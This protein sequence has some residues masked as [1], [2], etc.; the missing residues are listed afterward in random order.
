MSGIPISQR[1]MLG[2]IALGI[3]LS[4]IGAI[5]PTNTW[6]QVGPVALL[7]PMAVIALRRWPI[8]NR[9]AGCIAAFV[10]LHLFAAR[11]SYSFVPYDTW[12]GGIDSTLGFQRNMFD[13][14]V[15]FLFGLLAIDPIVELGTRY[16]R[17]TRRMA[18]I[19]AVLFVLAMGGFYEIFEWTL[20]LTLAPADAGA[21]NGEQGDIFDAQKDMALAALGALLA[22]PFAQRTS[23]ER[24]Q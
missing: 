9:S 10:L 24:T 8:G 3:P 12:L 20:T 22:L 11:W 21:Y 19:F 17:L 16:W 7:L 6:L 4:A 23:P 18:L 5:Y 13:R 2:A 14:L 15:H 1:W